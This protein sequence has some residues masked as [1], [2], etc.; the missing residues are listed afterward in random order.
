MSSG[1]DAWPPETA[2]KRKSSRFA[3]TITELQVETSGQQNSSAPH[4]P[5]AQIEVGLRTLPE[6]SKDAG[7]LTLIV[8]RRPDGSRETPERVLLTPEEG[9][10]DDKWNRSLPRVPDMQLTVMRRD[11]AELIANGQPLTTFGD[12]LFVELDISAASLPIGSRLRVGAAV[13]EVTPQAHNGCAKFKARF[14]SDAL[15][16]VNAPP[17]RPLN[18]RGIYWK[19]IEP[20]EAG[21]GSAIQVLSRP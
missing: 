21:V 15:H 13:V 9:L 5:L 11:V 17:T 6:A 16:F 14:G 18:L 3:R 7:R 1:K 20:G 2:T 10:S 4:L 19:V 8:R 12:N